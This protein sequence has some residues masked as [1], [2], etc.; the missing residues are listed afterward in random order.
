MAIGSQLGGHGTADQGNHIDT[1]HDVLQSNSISE[2]V[3]IRPPARQTEISALD[4]DHGHQQWPN[5][6]TPP[7]PAPWRQKESDL[8]RTVL[9]MV[10]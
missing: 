2:G 6:E 1:G 9:P 4:S 3:N 10:R 8:N 7:S 5:S